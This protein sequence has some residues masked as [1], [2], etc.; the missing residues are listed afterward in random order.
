V[1]LPGRKAL[2]KVSGAAVAF[3]DEAT[4][5]NV[6]RTRYQVTNAAKRVWDRTAAVV[7]ERDTGGGYG[8]VASTEYT[9]NRL[10]GTVIFNSAQA[11][12]AAVR[13]DGSYLPMST[14]AEAKAYSINASAN[15]ADASVF[16]DGWVKRQQARLDITGTIS[17]F[18]TTD[19]YFYDKLI[20]G[21]PVLLEF[22][23]D[24]SVDADT[25]VWALLNQEEITAGADG[26]VEEPIVW[27]GTQDAD[28]RVVSWDEGVAAGGG[29]GWVTSGLIHMWH[30]SAGSGQTVADT[31]GTVPLQLGTTS[32]ADV[33]DPTWEASPPVLLMDGVNDFAGNV[34]PNFV[35]D[36]PTFS[37]EGVL[38]LSAL[39][40][41]FSPLMGY[42]D[43]DD[44]AN[45]VAY[46][47]VWSDG[48]VQGSITDA[49]LVVRSANSSGGI[50]S[51]GARFQTF[52]T[53]DGTTLRVWINKVDVANVV[54]P[55]VYAPA[56]TNNV[57]N[58]G[59]RSDLGSSTV[60]HRHG[61]W[62]VYNRALNSSEITQN[63]NDRKT[64][65]TDL[66]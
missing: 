65:Y 29:S 46:F 30:P 47:G 35:G 21:E 31:V 66:P 38:R 17:K 18:K 20:A 56:G 13:V 24:S 32:G 34:S 51:A 5:A 2:V 15:N 6:D 64:V 63:Y 12:G 43:L 26:L 42:F 58:L 55:S 11:V 9:L 52:L 62:R 23:S 61:T 7:V 14:A 28:K 54:P 36:L 40:A 39:P 49:G 25:K 37:F 48:S 44:S 45:V 53:F 50:V 10:K 4:T 60:A 57:I 41:G 8:V 3:T 33:E 19:S 22:F 27:E 1:A 59:R 16:G